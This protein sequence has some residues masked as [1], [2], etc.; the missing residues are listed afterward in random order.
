MF[1]YRDKNKWFDFRFFTEKKKRNKSKEFT[2]SSLAFIQE[3]S[4]IY[5]D[6]HVCLSL[7]MQLHDRNCWLNSSKQSADLLWSL[8]VVR[9]HNNELIFFLEIF[10]LKRTEYILTRLFFIILTCVLKY[11]SV[12]EVVCFA[13]CMCIYY[14]KYKQSGVRLI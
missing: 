2:D 11:Y 3:C 8:D 4:R 5:V 9:F 1:L 6:M 10:I 14:C 13:M 7:Y 12:A